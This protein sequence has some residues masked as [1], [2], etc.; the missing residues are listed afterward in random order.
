MPA[1]Q[2]GNPQRKEQ[3]LW[4]L[5]QG[6]AYADWAEVVMAKVIEKLENATGL[7]DFVSYSLILGELS[8][9]LLFT[10]DDGRCVVRE[11]IQAIRVETNCDLRTAKLLWDNRE[12]VV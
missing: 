6:E 12:I 9:P 2:T 11:V 7:P 8:I 5:W 1:L 10:P 3:R 4:E